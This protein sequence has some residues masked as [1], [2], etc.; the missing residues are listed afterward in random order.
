[1]DRRFATA[2]SPTAGLFSPG[3]LDDGTLTIWDVA[4]GKPLFNKGTSN[5]RGGVASCIAF[6]NQS[7]TT[8]V[9]GGNNTLRVW[10]INADTGK[11]VPQDVTTRGIQR[12][13]TSVTVSDNDKA[14][15]AGTTSGDIMQFDL[16]QRLLQQVGP[17]RQ[18]FQKGV[19]VVTVR[20]HH[21]RLSVCKHASRSIR[22]TRC[23]GVHH[24]SHV[25]HSS[26]FAGAEEWGP[27]RRIWVGY[28]R[29]CQAIHLEDDP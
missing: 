9:C 26:S 8:F 20:H 2:C 16:S 10:D 7:D 5:G 6:A 24:V 18:K 13:I 21:I 1:L 28:S 23:Y 12:E 14:V 3:G 22:L 25:S 17:E 29:S 19:S 15:Y 11:A 27:A 4:T